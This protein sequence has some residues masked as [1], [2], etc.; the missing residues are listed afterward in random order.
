LKTCPERSR[1][2]EN[3]NQQ[4][5]RPDPFKKIANRLG[6]KVVKRLYFGLA[7]QQPDSTLNEKDKARAYAAGLKL[8]RSI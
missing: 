1:R 3:R 5:A 2:I 6:A 8:A 4:Q 7:A